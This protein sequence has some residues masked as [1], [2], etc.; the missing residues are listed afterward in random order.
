MN[1]SSEDLEEFIREG[2]DPLKEKAAAE[3][4]AVYANTPTTIHLDSLGRPFFSIAHNKR[5]DFSDDTIIEEFYSTYSILD[6]EGNLKAVIDACGNTVMQ[7]K[8]DMLG[9]QVYQ[10]SMDAGEKWLLND[11][12]SKPKYVWN[13]DAQNNNRD[14]NK[15]LLF[16]TRYDVLHR[17]LTVT[18][19]KE[20]VST[21]VER[22]E[23]RDA[24]GL[25]ETELNAQQQLNLIGKSV[26][27]YDEAGITRLVKCDFKG[28]ALETS[29]QYCKVYKDIPDW[30]EVSNV[31]MEEEAFV[32]STEFDALN[33]PVKMYT[34]HTN[35]IPASV[36]VPEYNEAN[37]L[38]AVTTNIRGSN[39]T[40]SFIT[41]IDYDAKGQRQAIYYGNNTKTRYDYDEKTFRLIRLLT[42]GNSGTKIFQD[43][44]YTYEAL[45]NITHIYDNAFEPMFF[46][47]RRIDAIAEYDYDAT[48]QLIRA[49]GRELA[50]QSNI[51][52]TA[53]NNNFRNFPFEHR[54][55]NVNDVQAVRNYTQQYV[56]D[57]V[58]NILKMQHVTDGGNWTRTYRYN[59]ND[60]D[61]TNLNI[62]TSAV[63]NNQLLAT[64]I[65][66]NTTRYA[67][68]IHGNML[69]LP[70][71]QSMMWNFK[72]QL[73]QVD[74]GG[75]GTA[76]YV[77]DSTGQRIRKVI[78]RNEGTKEERLYLGVIEI[79]RETSSAGERTKQTDTLHI[80]DNTKRI[81][82]VDTPVIKTDLDEEQVVRFIYSNHL[83]SFTLE[84]SD[85][86]EPGMIS[87]EEYH[88]YGTTAYSLQNSE[89]KVA[90][91]RYRYTGME[92][93]EE[94]GLNYHHARYY[95]NWLG[96]WIASDPIGIKG[97]NN[98]YSYVLNNP[99]N[100]TD[101]MGKAPRPNAMNEGTYWH[102]VSLPLIA[103]K[104][105]QYKKEGYSAHVEVK[106]HFGG[107]KKGVGRGE[108]D[109]VL[110]VV[111][112][113]HKVG[114]IYDLKTLSETLRSSTIRQIQG[115][116][117]FGMTLIR[118]DLPLQYKQG[119]ALE[120]I[121]Q[122]HP[123]VLDPIITFDKR[124]RLVFLSFELGKDKSGKVIPGVITYHVTPLHRIQSV[125]GYVPVSNP[126]PGTNPIPELFRGWSGLLPSLPK[127]SPVLPKHS[128][129]AINPQN[130][131]L[132]LPGPLPVPL[133]PSQNW[134]PRNP[135]TIPIPT[136]RLQVPLIFYLPDSVL[137]G[138]VDPRSAA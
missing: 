25:D 115:Y 82:M 61:R 77:Y 66:N 39:N 96:R 102:A 31:E 76:F 43:L 70:H 129:D 56:Y 11:C 138:Y 79:Y 95:A 71:L 126:V 111:E 131:I 15:I 104:I 98:L 80:V 86:E 34:P 58:G 14:D 99:I 51:N 1:P 87:Y 16:E 78:E 60:A 93:D 23:Y 123:D 29:R 35:E 136:P 116:I 101:L 30:K 10:N 137:P 91:K 44:H 38:N 122:A 53:T 117:P 133:E 13:I 73:A 89:I 72:D 40:T 42:T 103:E 75:G 45:G 5:K 3:K 55:V 37:L 74:L 26:V 46:N 54:G 114:H 22:M 134:R 49:T 88:P 97:G 12:M 33:R 17:P 20:N 112:E 124:G 132:P 83:G 68:D 41:N 50:G 105:N 81:A 65:S 90:A 24:K 121:F 108:I 4:T 63:K 85:E 2:K 7:Y 125:K 107:S 19:V 135:M 52:E 36:I 100:K 62:D 69:N 9:H 8:Y 84:L 21:V 59:N 130:P 47:N 110:E 120:K 32:S 67:H 48:Y 106:T 57:S 18:L 127:P 94:T 64:T 109:L 27:Q 6:I 28:N 128:P 113:G 118:P 119:T 92:R